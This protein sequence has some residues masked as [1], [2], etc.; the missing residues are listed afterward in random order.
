M[1]RA[2]PDPSTSRSPREGRPG[3]GV[4]GGRFGMV[5]LLAVI[6]LVAGCTTERSPSASSG[7]AA[8]SAAT[9]PG[10]QPATGGTTPEPPQRADTPPPAPPVGACY[11]LTS[12]SLT[13]LSNDSSPVPCGGRHTA[14]TIHVGRLDAVVDGHAVAVDSGVVRRQLARDCPRRLLG[15]LGGPRERLRLS[16][17]AVVW[18]SPSVLQ[19]DEGAAWFRCDVVAFD[20]GDTLFALPRSGDLRGVLSRPGALD[21][22][23][24]CGTAAPGASGFRRVIC[25]RPH[26][27]RAFDT[28]DLGRGRP[29]P[30]VSRVR[31]A[32]DTVCKDR[33]R[34]RAPSTLRFR[35]GW[36]W[37]TAEQWAAGRRYGYCWRPDA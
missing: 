7:V 20:R 9:A 34:S 15:Y 14:R 5:C 33:A 29:Y 22:F 25:A 2:D 17:F 35:Y 32:G 6:G 16:R 11:L 10:V 21:T 27:W 13:R 18:F 37:P 12:A 36:E 26:S 4:R 30:G 24:L 23:G 19:S 1:H 31:T 28:V 8:S 3:T